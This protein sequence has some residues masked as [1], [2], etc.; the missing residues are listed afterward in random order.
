M[1]KIAIERVIVVAEEHFFAP[2]AALGH[3]MRQIGNDKPADA[4]NGGSRK[5]DRHRPLTSAWATAWD[6]PA[7]SG[8]P[9]PAPDGP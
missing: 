5:G 3:V 2:I 1:Q 8:R 4:R 7:G 6:G 9:N